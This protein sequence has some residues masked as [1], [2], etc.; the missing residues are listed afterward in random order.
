ME[1]ARRKTRFH[2]STEE[3][4]EKPFNWKQMTRLFS[5]LAPY[6]KSLLPKTI[7]VMLLATAVRLIIP[8]FIGVFAVDRLEKGLATTADMVLYAGIVLGLYL[9]A[10]VANLF[11]IR[12]TNQLGQ[13][14]IF[15]IRKKLFDHIQHLSHRFYDQRSAGSILVRVINDVNSLQDLFTNG[16]INLL[17]DA[18]ML[19]GIVVILFSLSPELAVVILIVLPIMFLFQRNCAGKFAVLGK[20]CVCANLG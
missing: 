1:Q 9:F 3:I 17:M 20:P 11:R 6:A 7:F 4:I 16:V 12:W 19:V 10:Y 8:I 14:V 13:H 15:D 18:V 2:Y 5:F